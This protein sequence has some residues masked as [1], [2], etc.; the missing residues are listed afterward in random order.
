M[1]QLFPPGQNIHGQLLIVVEVLIIHLI[2]HGDILHQCQLVVFQSLCNPIHIGFGL[3]VLQLHG[4]NGVGSP[5]E[6][7]RQSLF[8]LGR[9]NALEFADQIGNH[10]ANL[11][12]VLGTDGFQ[13][14]FGEIRN[15]LLGC[16]AILQHLLRVADVNLLGKGLDRFLLLGGQHTHIRP[17]LRRRLRDLGFLLDFQLRLL[18]IRGQG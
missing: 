6:Q 18:Q 13:C 5:L 7:S 3:A 16:C 17:C 1:G 9:L 10:V 11:A 8:L 15:I 2:Q 12:H 4:F 14:A